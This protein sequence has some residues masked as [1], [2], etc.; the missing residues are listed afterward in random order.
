[1]STTTDLFPPPT[2][3]ETRELSRLLVRH[4]HLLHDL[5]TLRLDERAQRALDALLEIARVELM[6]PGG[7]ELARV[8]H[9][10]E[11]HAEDAKARE[12][13]ERDLEWGRIPEKPTR[14]PLARI[15]SETAKPTTRRRKQ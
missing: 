2:A 14:A 5:S 13:A 8:A 4:H 15:G 3:G 1:M 11:R 9:L 12:R 10:L 7:P 6:R